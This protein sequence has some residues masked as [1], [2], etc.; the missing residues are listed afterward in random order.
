M[1]S[2]E[3][4]WNHLKSNVF[5]DIMKFEYLN[6]KLRFSQEQKVKWSKKYIFLVS[7]V[8]FL[9]HKETLPTQNIADKTFK[10]VA[11]WLNPLKKPWWESCFR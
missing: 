11:V 7:Q 8:L 9:R 2:N 3:F 5:D 1:K 4:I 10:G 6:S